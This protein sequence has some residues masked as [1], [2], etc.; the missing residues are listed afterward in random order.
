MRIS[1][2]PLFDVSFDTGRH[3]IGYG[4]AR[5]HELLVATGDGGQTWHR[6]R[7]PCRDDGDTDGDDR[8]SLA[9][10]NVVSVLC[11]SEPGVGQQWKW[12][13]RSSDGGRTW[14]RRT[15]T[16]VGYL[17]GFAF[18]DSQRGWLWERRGWFL[19]TDDRGR[20]WSALP[21]GKPEKV[22][23]ESASFSTKRQG[24]ALLHVVGRRPRALKLVLMRT[25][26]GGKSW[27]RVRNWPVLTWPGV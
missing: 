25:A 22:E 27:V 7:F 15:A 14:V 9:A 5:G 3:G 20:T 4:V 12:L 11:V 6:L 26:D 1:R 19:R 8:V 18:G 10:P 17:M 2:Y 24:L 16:G 21:I 23:A 13:Y